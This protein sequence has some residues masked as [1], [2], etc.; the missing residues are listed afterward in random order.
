MATFQEKHSNVKKLEVRVTKNEDILQNW[1]KTFFDDSEKV[2]KELTQ[3]LPSNTSVSPPPPPPPPAPNGT[4]QNVPPPP[5]PPS[6]LNGPLPQ[7]QNGQP[8]KSKLSGLSFLAEIAQGGNLSR[9]TVQEKKSFQLKENKNNN[10]NFA[11]HYY[12]IIAKEMP[13]AEKK[14]NIQLLADST[15]N[16]DTELK[17]S[18]ESVIAFLQK[19]KNLQAISNTSTYTEVL[20][21]YK[22][23]QSIDTKAITNPDTI[24]RLFEKSFLNAEKYDAE[25]RPKVEQLKEMFGLFKT[26]IDEE[27]TKDYTDKVWKLTENAHEF[28]SD[29]NFLVY[30]KTIQNIK[31]KIDEL[32]RWSQEIVEYA[33]SKVIGNS[34][35]KNEKQDDA[36]NLLGITFNIVKDSIKND[37]DDIK[38]AKER[39]FVEDTAVYSDFIID[40]QNTVEK[41]P[42]LESFLAEK[43]P[44]KIVA[45]M[46]EIE[47]KTNALFGTTTFSQLSNR[48]TELK[49]DIDDHTAQA[50]PEFNDVQNA[51]VAKALVKKP[52]GSIFSKFRDEMF[53]QI[54]RAGTT[55][56]QEQAKKS[57]F[58]NLLN[59]QPTL[60]YI[61]DT[62]TR[63]AWIAFL[64]TY[65]N[66]VR[67]NKANM[68]KPITFN[69]YL[70]NNM[71][72]FI[73][74]YFNV[75]KQSTD[76]THDAGTLPVGTQPFLDAFI[77]DKIDEADTKQDAI[78][79]ER[80]KIEPK[81]V[82]HYETKEQTQQSNLFN[83]NMLPSL[84][85]SPDEQTLKE[86]FE[87]DLSFL[88]NYAMNRYCTWTRSQMADETFLKD[89][90]FTNSAI[91]Q[92]EEL[93]AV[94][95]KQGDF[96]NS[97]GELVFKIG[98]F[99]HP[100]AYRN[101]LQTL[102]AKTASAPKYVPP[103]L[104]IIEYVNFLLKIDYKDKGRVLFLRKNT[105]YPDPLNDAIEKHNKN[106]KALQFKDVP[107][108]GSANVTNRS[109]KSGN[110]TS[111]QLLDN[112]MQVANKKNVDEA[113][114]DAIKNSNDGYPE[115]I[116]SIVNQIILAI[117][118]GKQPPSPI[119]TSTPQKGGVPPVAPRKKNVQKVPPPV[120][121]RKK[122]AVP[123]PPVSPRNIKP[124]LN[125]TAAQLAT[126]QKQLQR[127]IKTLQTLKLQQK[128]D[129]LKHATKIATANK[130]IKKLR[131]QLNIMMQKEL[132]SLQNKNITAI[133]AHKKV[134]ALQ[135]QFENEK[136]QLETE[137][138]AL[139]SSESQLNAALTIESQNVS[140]L[141]Q[142]VSD[143]QQKESELQILQF[144][145]NTLNVENRTLKKQSL[146]DQTRRTALEKTHKR[147]GIAKLR[148]FLQLCNNNPTHDEKVEMLNIARA[149]N[150]VS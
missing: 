15:V 51:L 19:A 17:K 139:Q 20:Q 97:F 134:T 32:K 140:D 106:S 132:A 79:R 64:K 99:E 31:E 124:Q 118:H 7:P 96:L 53:D 73:G 98:G 114:S 67:N 147:E 9:G 138:A 28:Y 81:L 121:V 149:Y 136:K 40:P 150:I 125:A 142:R 75:Y 89:T 55:E 78:E 115:K 69:G 56:I 80:N 135:Q 105:D 65:Y 30:G 3:L 60:I 108:A 48:K 4:P 29:P 123:P 122:K 38:R 85:L 12:K 68:L 63:R 22:H 141:R 86:K 5:P 119:Q 110:L 44:R 91:I 41:K 102:T 130:K 33:L 111:K 128:N 93:K 126:A 54:E 143:L 11:T 144:Q 131:I 103:R 23:V 113:I 88:D 117:D 74:A 61:F 6:S 120:T 76:R 24:K 72:T 101:P 26:Y 52:T 137:V 27:G 13:N 66:D 42:R 14:K 46:L 43:L 34:I 37:D 25:D 104:S 10:R 90:I 84:T 62:E 18:F 133:Q 35:Q 145:Y 83:K 16:F 45:D 146:A 129:K 59:K 2:L 95:E 49:R 87:N 77:F 82:G 8:L 47:T 58:D 70:K 94:T 21:F 148:V 36:K 1:P 71:K 57:W 100:F 116:E 39:Q 127:G 109:F 92:A 112:L 107:P 50:R